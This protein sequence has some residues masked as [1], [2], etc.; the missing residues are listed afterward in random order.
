MVDLNNREATLSGRI[1]APKRLS[2]IQKCSVP[3]SLPLDL[4]VI[5]QMIEYTG[6]QQSFTKCQKR[7][8]NKA[9]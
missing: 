4:Y 2:A 5:R 3:Y 9:D 6:C 8:Q 7:Y 1:L